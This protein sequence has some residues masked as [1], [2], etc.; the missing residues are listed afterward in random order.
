MSE[1]EEVKKVQG[2][3]SENLEPKSTEIKLDNN[4]DNAGE[5]NNEKDAFEKDALEK[6]VLNEN[7][8]DKR[9]EKHSRNA[10]KKTSES[11]KKSSSDDED[12]E[13]FTIDKNS[14]TKEVINWIFTIIA[15][16]VIARMINSFIIVNARVPSA[17]METTIMTN[18]RLVANRLAYVFDEPEAGDVIVF[19]APDD[20]EKLFI[21]RVIGTPGDRVD[22]IDGDLYINTE[23]VQ[24]P[25]IKE[26]MVGDFGPYYVPE[27]N[28]FVLGDNRN[29]SLDARFWANT[30]VPE[31]TIL[32]KA[33]FTY[34]PK[35]HVVR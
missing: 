2:E 9:R 6:D 33:M 13:D 10:T 20:H 16:V 21:K 32:G 3:N 17:S 28:Y 26:P 23:L 22:I 8:K 5:I 15:C 30:Y 24:E 34:Y 35:I 7:K 1:N 18:D 4:A 14:I 27:D 25:Y 29:N 19:I 11:V 12:D 31:D